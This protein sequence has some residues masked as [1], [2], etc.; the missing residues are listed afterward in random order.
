MKAHRLSMSRLSLA[1]KC[2]YS[3]RPDVPAPPRTAGRAAQLGSLVHTLAEAKVTGRSSAEDVDAD[4]LS[5]AMQIATGPLDQFL[6][7]LPWTAC[8]KGFRYDAANDVCVEGPRRGEPGYET[9][10]ST[11]LPGTLDLIHVDGSRALVVDIKTGKPP[12]DSEQLYGQ[13]VAVSRFYK[14]NEVRI[15]YA[16]ALKTKLDL[17]NDEVLDADRLDAEAGRISGL[18]R[19][20]PTAAP[21]RGEHCWVCDARSW[22]PE[23]KDDGYFEDRAEARLYADDVRLFEGERT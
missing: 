12:K 16:R 22:C 20:L 19:R 21:N 8:E 4:L 11:S 18:L 10:G 6:S 9:I 3:F 5:E 17:L 23:W 1:H 14:L 15:Q 13:A 7:S 2:S